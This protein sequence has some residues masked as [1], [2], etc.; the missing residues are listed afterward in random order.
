M[1]FYLLKKEFHMKKKYHVYLTAEEKRTV[2]KALVDVRNS[3][4][5]AGHYTD[6]IDDLLIR[7][8]SLRSKNIRVVYK[9]DLSK[10]N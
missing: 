9:P 4:I 3:L 2:V 5:S 6:A 1:L 7:M 8:L 10:K